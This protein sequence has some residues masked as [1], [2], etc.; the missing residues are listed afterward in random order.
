MDYE[1]VNT[2]HFDVDWVSDG[3]HTALRKH[4]KKQQNQQKSTTKS[5]K[6]EEDD[7]MHTNQKRDLLKARVKTISWE[8]KGVFKK[9]LRISYFGM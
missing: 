9:Q 2:W 6:R 4:Y 1:K 3:L 8:S 5:T 7:C